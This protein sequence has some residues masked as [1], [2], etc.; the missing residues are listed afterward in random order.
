MSQHAGGLYRMPRDDVLAQRDHRQHLGFRKI[1]I[2]CRMP[3]I[4][5]FDADGTGV[6]ILLALPRRNPGMPGPH[7]F[8]HHLGDGT[9]FID[10]IMTGNFRDGIAQPAA[11]FP[12]VRHAGVMQDKHVRPDAIPPLFYIG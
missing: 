2:A 12:G 7:A 8:I 4:L 1:R 11:G 6:Q 5:D 9:D 10:Q 3:W